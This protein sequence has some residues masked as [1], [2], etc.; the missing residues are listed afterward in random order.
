VST[1]DGGVLEN[2][3]V[4]A[5]TQDAAPV[6]VARG[7]TDIAGNYQ[8]DG[9]LAGT[10]DLRPSKAGFTFEP[11]TLEVAVGPN[12][13]NNDFVAF[14]LFTR[15]FQ[16][17]LAFV[18]VPADPANNDVVAAFGTD[19]IAR[20]DPRRA[21]VD[22]YVVASLEPDAPI[23][24]L[25]PGRGYFVDFAAATTVQV[26]GRLI[27]VT[28][29][30]SLNLQNGF[31]MLGNP[32][33]ATLPWANLAIADTG[34]VA[35]FGFILKPGTRDYELVSDLPELK[36]RKSVPEA[37]GFWLQAQAATFVTVNPVGTA[38]AAPETSRPPKVDDHNW[39]IPIVA[40]TIGGADLSSRAGI[41]DGAALQ[42]ANPP[43]LPGGVD[44][45]F[46]GNDNRQL[47]LDVRAAAAAKTEWSFAVTTELKNVPVTVSLPDLTGVPAGMRVTLVDAAAG[48]T[49][50]ARQLVAY[51][52][53]SRDGG[54]RPF[55]LV[56]EPDRGGN[57]ALVIA[58]A[59]ANARTVEVNYTLAKAAAM[60][61][62]V[63]N[64]AGR[65]V[66]VVQRA[67]DTPAGQNTAVWNL[68]S[69]SGTAVP[70]GTYLIELQA[71]AADG[72]QA[73]AVRAVSV[74]R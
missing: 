52:Y 7:R 49:M 21:G 18:A 66:A 1:S 38:D 67:Q 34:P 36:A 72:Q 56:V 17:G 45:Y 63:L 28:D 27:R 31:N 71:V 58:A 50:N 44:V 35:D 20:W 54:E 40:R 14:E 60:T 64:L 61:V 24:D 39:V 11:Q 5:L 32:Y 2:A 8:L 59:Q 3:L 51:T 73:R 53:D 6:V 48:K 19:A 62:R 33:P 30:F 70:A 47:A 42:A 68:L 12:A 46:T 4:E 65:E 43:A 22:K 55:R 9:L 69:A 16:T 37:A 13:V 41:T 26:G 57:L 74:S 15:Q 29:P 23:L 10:Y 25:G